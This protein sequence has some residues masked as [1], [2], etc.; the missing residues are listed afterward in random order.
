M[1]KSYVS[2]VVRFESLHLHENIACDSC[3]NHGRTDKF[4]IDTD[5]GYVTIW[6]K[7]NSCHDNTKY[8]IEKTP[9]C[10][11]NVTCL[12]PNFEGHSHTYSLS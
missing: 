2:P 6:V 3:W 5:P 11:E 1:K 7:G 12:L 10:T 4:Y 8:K 9:N